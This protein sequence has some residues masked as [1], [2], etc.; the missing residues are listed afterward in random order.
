MISFS[1]AVLVIFNNIDPISFY[2]DRFERDSIHQD[3]K[4]YVM[5]NQY[6]FR[7]LLGC[8]VHMP[9]E[10]T[11]LLHVLVVKNHVTNQNMNKLM[12]L[13]SELCST[14]TTVVFVLC[15]ESVV[16]LICRGV[17]PSTIVGG[18]GGHTYEAINVFVSVC[19][20]VCVCVCVGGG[21]GRVLEASAHSN[22]QI[23]CQLSPH[24]HEA[25]W[26]FSHS[27]HG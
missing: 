19:V 8:F 22:Y 1:F 17:D 12:K 3:I 26:S 4:S 5:H 20:R 10:P 13:I 18:G 27:H 11:F 24:I 2:F 15:I 7:L 16:S 9:I 21:G 6:H 23:F 25:R 14:F